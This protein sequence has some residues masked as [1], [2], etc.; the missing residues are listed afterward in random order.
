M[1]HPVEVNFDAPAGYRLVG[2]TDVA[3][4]Y[5]L[6]RIGDALSI[7][8]H[9]IMALGAKTFLALKSFVSFC[10][11][12]WRLRGLGRAFFFLWRFLA[13]LFR[14]RLALLRG[15]VFDFGVHFTTNQDGGAG[16][17]KP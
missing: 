13:F 9:S 5:G 10:A 11:F 15:G 3:W 2:R 8:P 17:V 7:T 4:I 6:V 14:V 1:A 16:E 12:L